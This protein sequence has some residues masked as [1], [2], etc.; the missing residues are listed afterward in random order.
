MVYSNS[1]LSLDKILLQFLTEEDT[2]LSMLKW[3][4]E[5]LMEV[6]VSAKIHA[7]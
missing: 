5:Q 1:N 7:L 2:M 3:L 4:C 6:E